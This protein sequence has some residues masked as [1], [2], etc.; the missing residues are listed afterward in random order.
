MLKK[1]EKRDQPSSDG[2]VIGKSSQ[3][4]YPIDSFYVRTRRSKCVLNI[5]LEDFS[6][7]HGQFSDKNH[8]SGIDTAVFSLFDNEKIKFQFSIVPGKH[9]L[10]ISGFYNGSEA[11]A[12]LFVDV[13]LL[14]RQGQKYQ[15]EYGRK[16]D[17]QIGSRN[18]ESLNNYVYDRDELEKKRDKLFNNDTLTI[19]ID[20]NATWCEVSN[21][22]SL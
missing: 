2:Y 22:S 9:D 10:R 17:F 20:I 11:S 19:C 3:L 13:Y 18:T 21:K 6:R 5:A 15:F 12:N 8:P 14:D 4:E 16:I 7:I 1:T